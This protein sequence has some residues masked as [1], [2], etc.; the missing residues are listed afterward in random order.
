VTLVSK[1]RSR[2]Q[3]HRNFDAFFLKMESTVS[4]YLT[5]INQLL[6]KLLETECEIRIAD[7]LDK[8]LALLWQQEAKG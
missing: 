3:L 4:R 6:E 5:K 8:L 1:W 7:Y 2:K